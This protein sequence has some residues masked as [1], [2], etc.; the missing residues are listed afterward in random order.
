MR[1]LTATKA[2]IMMNTQTE[3]QCLIC[4]KNRSLL[5]D[6]PILGQLVGL[7]VLAQIWAHIAALK[8]SSRF[9]V[10]NIRQ[11]DKSP[12]VFADLE[13]ITARGEYYCLDLEALLFHHSC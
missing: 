9:W 8:S 4:T 10:T 2:W 1:C 3:I 7:F 5:I 12:A 13:R 6:G 11:W